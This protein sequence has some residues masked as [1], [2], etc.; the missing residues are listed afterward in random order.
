LRIN[1]KLTIN[2]I[3]PGQVAQ[4][5]LRLIN[6]C[7][8]QSLE[9]KTTPVYFCM[10]YYTAMMQSFEKE[11]N[12]R[13][14]LI[15]GGVALAMIFAFILIKFPL[16]RIELQPP[17]MYVEVD[18]EDLVPARKFG[19][20]GGGGNTVKADQPK[21]IAK[22]SIPPGDTDDSKDFETNDKDIAAPKV[23]KPANPKP[24]A[25]K[26]NPNTSV[27]KENPKPIV[28][29]PAPPRPK[30][31]AGKTLSGTGSG[32]GTADKY[33][34]AGGNGTG[35]GVGRGPGYGGTGGGSGG[36]NGTGVG[37]GT[38]PRR[39]SGNRSIITSGKLDAGENISG[40]VEAE[41]R[42][43][44]DGIGTLVRTVRGSLMSDGQAK[45]IIRDWLRR[46]RFNRTGEESVVVYE[47]NIRTGG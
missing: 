30:A 43:S 29:T 20:G 39:V 22:P 7:V 10:N 15:T 19:G 44:A 14:A 13:A 34:I 41:I 18:L 24:D 1:K 36:G 38:G 12:K 32:G 35:N 42:V 47:F 33:D 23:N 28:E 3:A 25:P 26:V 5:L 21:G 46:N 17:L 6:R 4:A 2:K 40:K 11:K 16:P 31:V 27:V 8:K 45:D 37:T 9:F